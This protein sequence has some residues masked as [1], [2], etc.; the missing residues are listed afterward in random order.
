[1]KSKIRVEYDFDKKEPY[2]Q[3]YLEKCDEEPDMRD[4]MLKTL[5]QSANHNPVCVTYP[6]HN[7]DNSTPQIRLQ[8]HRSFITSMETF[9][10]SIF[11]GQPYDE[12]TNFEIQN[13]FN[14][15]SIAIDAKESPK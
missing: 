12:S 10:H 7:G 15:M 5:I 8:D 6:I 4:N 9:C 1:M 11:D 2:I 13:F 3:F 14:K